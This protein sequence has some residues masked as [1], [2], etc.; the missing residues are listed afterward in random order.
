M[1]NLLGLWQN[2]MDWY[3]D[4]AV[5]ESPYSGI[6]QYLANAFLPLVIV[7]FFTFFF[8]LFYFYG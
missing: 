1:K 3:E 4:H 7:A 2:F 5:K 6:N 8:T